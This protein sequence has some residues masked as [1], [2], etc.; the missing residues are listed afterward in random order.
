MI[1][2]HNRQ[3]VK[4]ENIFIPVNARAVVQIPI[5]FL[6]AGPGRNSAFLVMLV[7]SCSVAHADVEGGME[8]IRLAESEL[9]AGL[10][11][12]HRRG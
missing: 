2:A 7:A 11:P 6:P 12:V 10:A 4:L 9:L 1:M 8:A 3:D 5:A